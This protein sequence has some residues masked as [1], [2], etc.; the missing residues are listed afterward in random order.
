MKVSWFT[1]WPV[2]RDGFILAVTQPALPPRVPRDTSHL[3]G[4]D[5]QI[6]GV[7]S[8]GH[9]GARPVPMLPLRAQGEAMLGRAPCQ[10]APGQEGSPAATQNSI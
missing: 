7:L 6:P 10:R 8:R 3:A 4:S 5:T 2:L 1:A 9:R